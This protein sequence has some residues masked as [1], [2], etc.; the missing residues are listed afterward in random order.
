M[1][2]RKKELNEIIDSNG[3][4]IGK[5][6]V[7]TTGADLESQASNTTDNNARIATQPYR[8]D[9]L[10]RFGFTMFPFMEGEENQDQLELMQELVS[11]LS[12]KDKGLIE[13][14]FRNPNKIKPDFRKISEGSDEPNKENNFTYAKKIMKLFEKHFNK[15]FDNKIDESKVVEDKMIEKKNEDEIAEKKEDKEIQDKQ[16]EK[17]AGLIN[18][19]DAE[20]KGKLKNLLE[21]NG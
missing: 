3:E 17:I 19:L 2:I 16:L 5:N 20:A 18:K 4:I 7:P 8:Y 10:G 14:Y 12:D 21:I 1:K 6:D 11:L 9:M 13:N 15:A